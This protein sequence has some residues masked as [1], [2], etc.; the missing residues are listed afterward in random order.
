MT[1]DEMLE[2]L[3]KIPVKVQL[4]MLPTEGA[5]ECLYM[6][7][8]GNRYEWIG[9]NDWPASVI[10]ENDSKKVKY[11]LEIDGKTYSFDDYQEFE[12]FFSE[13]WIREVEP[14]EDCTD[15]GLKNWLETVEDC[16][17]IPLY[18]D[19]EDDEVDE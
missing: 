3:H 1:R 11:T 13:N 7:S 9:I 8:K 6:N 17:G 12:T 14:W 15:E 16:E 10:K 4:T 18:G 2:K 5:L 19:Y